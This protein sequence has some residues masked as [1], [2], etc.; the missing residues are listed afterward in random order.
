[1]MFKNF[2]SALYG[3]CDNLR[4]FL[5]GLPDEIKQRTF[6]IRLRAGCPVTLTTPDG[7][8]YISKSGAVAM[9]NSEALVYA[10]AADLRKSFDMICDFSV[11]THSEEISK[12]YVSMRCGHRAGISGRAV[13]RQGEITAFGEIYSINIRIARQVSGVAEKALN[14]IYDTFGAFKSFVYFGPPG[15]G[16]TTYLRDTARLLSKSNVRCALIDERGEVAAQAGAAGFD[17]GHNCDIISGCPKPH[18]IEMAVRNLNPQVILFD[19]IGTP[20][21][22]AAVADGFMCGV[23]VVT[24]AH[25]GNLSELFVRPAT[26]PLLEPGGLQAAVFLPGVGLKEQLFILEDGQNENCGNY[27]PVPVVGGDRLFKKFIS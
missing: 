4:G 8:L 21:E 10:T 23:G 2:D 26:R 11:H 24:T 5:A 6:E 9:V 7:N 27:I 1:M 13:I 3:V 14:S 19:E 20:A 17:L 22:A 16:K 15:C 25:A 18:A 12:G